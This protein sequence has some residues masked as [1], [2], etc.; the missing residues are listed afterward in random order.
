MLLLSVPG[1]TNTMHRNWRQD[2]RH[3]RRNSKTRSKK[4]NKSLLI[5][6]SVATEDHLLSG[7]QR[8]ARGAL[9]GK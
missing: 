3:A 6:V 1:H 9:N 4:K 8:D 5:E 2:R 7:F